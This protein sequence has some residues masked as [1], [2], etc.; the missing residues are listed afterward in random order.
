MTSYHVSKS[1]SEDVEEEREMIN[2]TSN[3]PLPSSYATCAPDFF[4]DLKFESIIC[5]HN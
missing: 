2:V 1:V 3:L 4:T 5:H